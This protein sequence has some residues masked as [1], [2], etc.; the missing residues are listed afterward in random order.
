M[1]FNILRAPHTMFQWRGLCPKTPTFTLCTLFE[2]RRKLQTIL[3]DYTLDNIFDAD[4]TGL[5]FRMAPNQTLASA[6]T[7]GTKLDKTRITVLLATNAIGI[8][9]LKSLVIGSSKNPKCLHQVNRN[10]LS[11]TY[12]ANSK[13]WMRNN[14]FGEWLEVHFLPL[15]ITAHLQLMDA[16]IIKSFK[17]IYKQHYIRHIIHQFEANVDLKSNKINVKE[18]MEYVA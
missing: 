3:Q 2:E 13:A 8:Q 18:A 10:F 7:P 16:D 5:F 11:C 17:A 14:I 6:P 9:K 4:E 1:D 12:H 15:N